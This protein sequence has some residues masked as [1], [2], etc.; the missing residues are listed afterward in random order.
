MSER[1]ELDL[2]RLM[3]MMDKESCLQLV[4]E[5]MELSGLRGFSVGGLGKK[6]I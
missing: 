6:S 5:T 2:N 3:P 4:E 1:R